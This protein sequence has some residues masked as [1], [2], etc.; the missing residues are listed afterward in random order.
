LDQ[1]WTVIE[2]RV[3]ELS[4]KSYELFVLIFKGH[5]G[6]EMETGKLDMMFQGLVTEFDKLESNERKLKI[7]LLDS[8]HAILDLLRSKDLALGIK[9]LPSII[10]RLFSKVFTIIFHFGHLLSVVS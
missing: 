5:R 9:L 8:I 1:L 2:C 10:P 7:S 4:I 6:M 3:S